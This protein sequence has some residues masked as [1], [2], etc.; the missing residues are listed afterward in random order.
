[1][2][3]G[4]ASGSAWAIDSAANPTPSPFGILQ[5]VG[6]D[7]SFSNKEL[8]GQY[9]FPVAVG[10]GTGKI[11][12][13]AQAARLSGRLLN[14]FFGGTKAAGQTSVAQDESA[15]IPGTPFQI[16]VAN[17]ATW[18]T[19]LGVYDAATSIPF[20][21]V[22]AAPAAGQYT[23]SAGGVYL[24]NTADTG[25]TVKISYTFTIA[26]TG[27][28]ITI[29]NPLMGVAPTFKTVTTQLFNNLR[30]TLTLNSNVFSKLGIATKSEDF[31]IPDFD[32]SAQADAAN[33]IGTWS[34]A[35]A[36]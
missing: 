20:V 12:C 34:L 28:T 25:K 32:W 3:F 26:S 5:N 31:A 17:G 33:N 30:S 4:F 15:A 29:S 8:T 19:D 11:S 9:G 27:E 22:A 10:R 23:V 6:V 21:R 1:M 24:F 16:T 18:V 13:K 36:S 35:E 14:L 2:Q 7:F